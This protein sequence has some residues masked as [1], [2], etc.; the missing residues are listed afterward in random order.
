MA[1]EAKSYY[2]NVHQELIDL[3]KEHNQTAQRKVYRLYYK[4][5]YNTSLR[6]VSD[7][8][9]AED[10]MQESFLKAFKKIH[11]YNNTS[12]FGAWLKRIVINE[13]IN[14]VRKSKP[15]F[16]TAETQLLK[17]QDVDAAGDSS[18]DFDWKQASLV[19]VK[20]AFSGLTERY[21]TVISLLL[22]EGYDL[23]ETA[24]ILGVTYGNARVLYFRAKKK[25]EELVKEEYGEF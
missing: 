14:Y 20:Q 6:I 10:I 13:S 8:H 21:R 25:L 24:E 19:K 17:K 1:A 15:E 4:A 11:L 9:I 12:S 23:E 2:L 5:M 18:S 22:L 7:E 16:L 3:C